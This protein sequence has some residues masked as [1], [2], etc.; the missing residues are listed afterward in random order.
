[1]PLVT[2]ENGVLLYS[3]FPDLSLVCVARFGTVYRC[4]IQ[5]KINQIWENV[6]H[7]SNIGENFMFSPM[8]EIPIA[9]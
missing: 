2:I 1:M 8:C 3:V 4:Y 5:R 9:E 6:E 7:K